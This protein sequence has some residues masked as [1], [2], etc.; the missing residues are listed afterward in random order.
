[1]IIFFH[2]IGILR[3]SSQNKWILLMNIVLIHHS[4][5]N[6]RKKLSS[7]F[8]HVPF[9]EFP[10]SFVFRQKWILYSSKST[11]F[12]VICGMKIVMVYCLLLPHD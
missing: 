5:L 2:Q 8:K 1:M 7:F 6:I 4:Y 12:S 9:Y 3:E 11:T 10:T